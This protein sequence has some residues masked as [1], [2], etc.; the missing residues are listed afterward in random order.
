MLKDLLVD[1]TNKSQK[2][3]DEAYKTCL[4]EQYLDKVLPICNGED[5][6]PVEG[7]KTEGARILYMIILRKLRPITELTGCDFLHAWW[8]TVQCE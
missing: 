6:T 5:Q 2:S 8:D 4:F 3:V 1:C 7:L